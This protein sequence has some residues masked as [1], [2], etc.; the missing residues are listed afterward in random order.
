MQKALS[1]NI[2]IYRRKVKKI[3]GIYVLM[4]PSGSSEEDSMSYFGFLIPVKR[5]CDHSN[6]NK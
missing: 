5:H 3:L 1:S 4:A 6:S 2:Y